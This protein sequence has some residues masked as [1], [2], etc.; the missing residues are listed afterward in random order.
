MIA[1]V[2]FTDGRVDCIDQ[3]IRSA[4]KN[5]H[6]SITTKLINDDS[7]DPEYRLWLRQNFEPLGFRL[8]PP[9]EG[10]QGFGGAI[11]HAWAHL[12]SETREPFVFH[13]E[14]D[15]TFNRPVDLDAMAF[16]LVN[17]PNLVQLALRRQPWNDEE[18][19]AGGI[20]EQ[21]PHDYTQLMDEHG[22]A[23]L[24][25]RRFFTTN[26]SIYRRSL[27]QRTWPEGEHS[28]GLFTHDLLRS[29]KTRFAFWGHRN[30]DPWVTHIGHQ[31]V[32]VGY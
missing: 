1:L 17:H 21:H 9:A 20:V 2:V 26:P 25:H 4:A 30:D 16:T 27:L 10:R 29:E 18:S 5:L 32:G 22:A 3:T 14:D 23:W 19:A 15:F 28:E 6:G 8:I 12:K 7:D 11:R 13:L 24:E 31:R